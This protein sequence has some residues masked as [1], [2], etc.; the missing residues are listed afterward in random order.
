VLAA[1]LWSRQVNLIPRILGVPGHKGG[2]PNY[3]R[4]KKDVIAHLKQETT[5]YC[6]TMLDFYG[7]ESGFPGMPLPTHLSTLEKVQRLEE[8]VKQ[9]I[10]QRIPEFRPEDRFLPYLQLHE[11]E[12]LLFSNP[13]G[14]AEA[15]KQPNLAHRFLEVRN[16]FATPEDI[17]DGPT[18]APSKRVLALYPSYQKVIEGTLAASAVGVEVMKRECPHFRK[19]VERLE[20]LN[21]E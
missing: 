18:T 6:S 5:V 19:W 14:F 15:I 9:D 21:E 20:H 11:Y 2:R 12:G 16:G 1:S 8:A 4:V 17:N 13:Q 7:L 3:E 10:C